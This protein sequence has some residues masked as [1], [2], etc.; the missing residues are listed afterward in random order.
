[1]PLFLLSYSILIYQLD[2]LCGIS[3]GS[4]VMSQADSKTSFE[5]ECGNLRWAGGS[6]I[7]RSLQ[8]TDQHLTA[9][10]LPREQPTDTPNTSAICSDKCVSEYLNIFSNHTIGVCMPSYPM[11]V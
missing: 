3:D 4:A 6:A 7:C 11:Y 10:Q 9:P 8:L 1:M 2:T 5:A